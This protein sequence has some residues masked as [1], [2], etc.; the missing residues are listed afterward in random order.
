MQISGF[1][2]MSLIDYPQRISCVIFTQG[3]VF[4]CPFCHNPDLIPVD[5]KKQSIY[6]EEEVL[7]FLQKRQGMLDG[8]VVSGGE[9]TIQPD[10]LP[11]MKKAK[12]LNLL[13]KLD[14]MGINPEV[15]ESAINSGL[16]DYMAM[17]IK[18][19]LNKYSQAIGTKVN[20]ARIKKTVEIIKNSQIEY[21]FRTTCVPG[22]HNEEDFVEIADWLE[23]SKNY[24]IQ[25]F[26]SGVTNDPDLGQKSGKYSLDL[27]KIREIMQTAIPN[28]QIRYNS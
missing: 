7:N 6:T 17:D 9:P 22:I 14:T 27:E 8:L 20:L 5:R 23:G 26:R 18:H 10:L 28:V 15:V 16:V 3:C 24:Y 11:F 1:Q 19:T 25:E 13:I 2:K 21:E 4:N 12:E